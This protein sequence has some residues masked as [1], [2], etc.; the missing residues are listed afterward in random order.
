M[1]GI[2]RTNACTSIT[3]GNSNSPWQLPSFRGLI[4][5][6]ITFK[7]RGIWGVLVDASGV[8]LFPTLFAVVLVY[9]WNRS[10]RPDGQSSSRYGCLPQ[11]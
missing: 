1:L 2:L 11:A 10:D 6:L 3:N 8:H 9:H 7:V 5:I 4:Y